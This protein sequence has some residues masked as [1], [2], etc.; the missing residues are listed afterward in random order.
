MWHT[1]LFTIH[2]TPVTAFS[3][4]TF[5]GIIILTWIIAKCLRKGMMQ[6][7]FLKG[8][9]SSAT[10]YGL[11]RF[12]YYLTLSIGAYIALT[13]VG[14]DLTGIAVV[15][16]AL[17][18]GIGFGLQSVFNNFA[19]GIILLIE[20]KVSVGDMIQ[21][22]SGEMGHVK[23]INVR[24]T[25]IQSLDNRKILVP[26]T[27]IVSKKLTNWTLGHEKFHRFRIP[28]TVLRKES[29]EKVKALALEVAEEFNVKKMASEVWLSQIGEKHQDFELVLWMERE[30][31]GLSAHSMAARCLWSLDTAFTKEGIELIKANRCVSSSP[32]LEEL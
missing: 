11:G 3:L 12:A 4:L 2:E 9:V 30:E 13:V 20:R 31:K 6:F 8:N 23:E 28:F 29:K 25:L 24:S 21:L 32:F 17:S 7:P 18:V 19:A 14:V 27:E 1:P 10:L 5:I 15:I 26:N 16:G 22:E